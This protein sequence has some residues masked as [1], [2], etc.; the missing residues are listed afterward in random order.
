MILATSSACSFVYV[1]LATDA[2]TI[3]QFEKNPCPGPKAQPDRSQTFADSVVSA[4]PQHKRY[5][6]GNKHVY[7]IKMWAK[8]LGPAL[9]FVFLLQDFFDFFVWHRISNFGFL[10]NFGD[11]LEVYR[12]CTQS[13]KWP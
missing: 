1:S 9:L 4:V 7:E 5:N 6:R 2:S 10:P 8:S 13:D 12:Q 11:W 3:I